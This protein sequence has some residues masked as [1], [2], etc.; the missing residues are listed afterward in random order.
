MKDIY[1]FIDDVFV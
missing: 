1:D